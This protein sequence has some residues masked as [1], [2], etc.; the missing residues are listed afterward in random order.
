MQTMQTIETMGKIAGIGGLALG[1]FLLLFRDV[2]RKNIFAGLTR[3]QS[4]RIIRLI[5]ILVWS[6]TLA[7]IAAWLVAPMIAQPTQVRNKV[8]VTMDSP[9]LVYDSENSGTGRTNTDEIDNALKDIKGISLVQVS[10]NLA[11]DREEEVRSK[12]PDLIIIHASAFA[13]ETL[14]P[15]TRHSEE[16]K[17]I[18]FF[19][20]MVGSSAKFLVYSR[21]P[22][23][24]DVEDQQ[25]RIQAIER[26]VPGIQGRIQFFNFVPGKPKKFRDPEVQRELKK[27]VRSIL[28]I[29]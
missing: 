26:K 20:Y 13:S 22:L 21:S 8:V 12:N 23:L 18:S 15:E 27:Q 6:I 28:G 29:P 2:I 4:F 10:T 3:E 7:G 9:L 19:E 14:S 17:L 16:R 25:A 1:V 24:E 5:L 11:W